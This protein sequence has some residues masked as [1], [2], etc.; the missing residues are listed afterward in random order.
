MRAT[1]C[2]TDRPSSYCGIA[3]IFRCPFLERVAL[4]T[5]A[6]TL[7]ELGEHYYPFKPPSKT[8]PLKDWF[9]FFYQLLLDRYRCEYVFK[10]A[11]GS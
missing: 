3:P 4:G 1:D 9:D 6:P 5:H 2:T 8:A 7:L 10:Y 11:L